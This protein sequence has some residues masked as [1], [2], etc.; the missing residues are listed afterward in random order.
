MTSSFNDPY[1]LPYASFGA[2][3]CSSKIKETIILLLSLLLCVSY[4]SKISLCM[5]WYKYLPFIVLLLFTQMYTQNKRKVN[6]AVKMI[7][8]DTATMATVAPRDTKQ[9]TSNSN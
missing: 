4:K 1:R 2:R 9:F 6:M 8:S 7:A 5:L 3:E